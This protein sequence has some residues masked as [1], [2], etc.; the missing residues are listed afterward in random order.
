MK[1]SEVLNE[2]SEVLGTGE[3]LPIF[4]CMRGKCGDTTIEQT[5]KKN[6]IPSY[7]TAHFNDIFQ[8]CKEQGKRIKIITGIR[9]P[10]AIQLS[11]LYQHIGT[12]DSEDFLKHQISKLTE[13]DQ[14][15]LKEK[16]DAQILYDCYFNQGNYQIKDGSEK[17]TVPYFD[18][19]S[20]H[21]IDVLNYPFSQEKGYTVI[22]DGKIEIFLYQLE[23]L[24]DLLPELS[25][26]VGKEI[27][28]FEN[29]NQASGK[30]IAKSYEIAKKEIKLS[31]KT[32]KEAYDNEYMKHFYSPEALGKMKEKW[33][34]HISWD[35]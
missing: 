13:A 10:L 3:E 30:W 8:E 15:K 25:D 33:C 24:N 11:T 22:R 20:E 28:S 31:E 17:R 26:F 2:I 18:S 12:V 9:D 5:L 29:K 19:F 32:V 16:F 34:K 14:D 23:K 35:K 21:V 4:V 1:R 6:L 7:M 27:Q